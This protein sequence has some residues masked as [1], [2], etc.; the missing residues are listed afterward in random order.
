MTHST[1]LRHPCMLPSSTQD[2][3]T[4]VLLVLPLVVAVAVLCTGV[5][6]I[7]ITSPTAASPQP[8]VG[9]VDCGAS[10]SAVSAV[11]TGNHIIYLGEVGPQAMGPK[12]AG[13]CCIQDVVGM[14]S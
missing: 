8:F 13:G 4:F 3:Q 14:L 7:R 12:G 6:G 2:Q 5:W 11:Y 10:F 9:I 1:G